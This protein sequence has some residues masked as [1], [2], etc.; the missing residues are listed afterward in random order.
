M[1][2]INIKMP[3][4]CYDCPFSDDSG[5]YPYCWALHQARGYNFDRKTK[6]FPN[7]PLREANGSEHDGEMAR[8][9]DMCRV[10]FNRCRA[11]M[12]C[13]GAM[14]VFCGIRKECEEAHSL[15]NQAQKQLREEKD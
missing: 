8:Q 14:C 2:Q 9:K 5:D 15:T 6:R 11:V 4:R 3:N 1:I 13:G 7:C 12:S 10:L